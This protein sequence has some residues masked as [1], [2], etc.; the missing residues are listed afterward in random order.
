[1]RLSITAL[2]AVI[3]LGWVVSASAAPLDDRLISGTL[4]WPAQ[5]GS[6]N[7]VVVRG[8]DGVTYFV[9]RS[10][11][12]LSRAPA[13]SA[14]DRVAVMAR[15]G[16]EAGQ[17]IDGAIDKDAGTVSASIR[18]DD[19]SAT[20]AAP[21]ITTAPAE[22][23]PVPLPRGWRR[24]R[25]VVESVTGSTATVVEVGGQRTRVDLAQLMPDIRDEIRP[26]QDVVLLGPAAGGRMTAQG[27]VIDH[28][29]PASALPR[30]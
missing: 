24:V 2:T 28:S 13:L 7:R 4:L 16:F 17:L 22:A 21:A 11:L 6:E 14:G 3:A 20:T 12:D 27:A 30:Q 8:D 18:T 1:M 19:A 15:E 25:G 10:Q 9:K 5:L 26:G 23:P 29:A